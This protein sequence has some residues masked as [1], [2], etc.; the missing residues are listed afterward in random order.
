MGRKKENYA[1]PRCGY[2]T[3]HKSS[4]VTHLFKTKKPCPAQKD[5]IHLDDTIKN[6]ILE[7]R[8]YRI[9]TPQQN[10]SVTNNFINNYNI[11]NN[12]INKIDPIEK[13]NQFTNYKHIEVLGIDDTMEDRY[14]NKVKRLDNDGYKYGF[15]LNLNDLLEAIDEVSRV[16]TL[17]DFN[18]LY[19]ARFDRLKIYDGEWNEMLVTSGIKRLIETIQDYYWNAYECFLLRKIHNSISS[20]EVV[21]SK[22]LL[23]EYF[24]FIGCFD[25][26]PFLKNKDDGEI[27]RKEY[28]DPQHTIDED[29]GARYAKIRD[30]TTKS[31]INQVRKSVLDIIKKNTL[32]NIDELNKKVMELFHIDEKFKQQLLNSCNYISDQ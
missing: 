8:I 5:D 2:T 20:V 22:E 32:R 25:V 19:C 16:R 30:Q 17:E 23:D 31:E 9:P 10:A 14:G 21:R 11:L 6:Y 26:V 18:I 27:L 12:F 7:N 15:E 3:C 1:C 4:M 24:K 28:D 29:Y 13:L